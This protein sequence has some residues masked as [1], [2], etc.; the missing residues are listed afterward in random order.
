LFHY[1]LTLCSLRSTKLK[2]YDPSKR[3]PEG[4]RELVDEKQK[5]FEKLLKEKYGIIIKNIGHG[6]TGGGLVGELV[7]FC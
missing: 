3:L 6:N 7:M 2:T 4:Y 5:K 1:L